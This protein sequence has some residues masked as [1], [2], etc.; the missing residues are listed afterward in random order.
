MKKISAVMNICSGRLPRLCSASIAKVPIADIST[1]AVSDTPS[2]NCSATALPTTSATSHAM[3]AI[4]QVI[5]RN[6][7]VRRLKRSRHRRARSR[8]V[9][10]PT[11]DA[12]HCNSMPIRLA[13]STT[14]SN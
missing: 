4:S 1:P 7:V 5:Q 2:S 9:T 6:T 12:T 8:P 11:R 10:T 3:I 14:L 13:T